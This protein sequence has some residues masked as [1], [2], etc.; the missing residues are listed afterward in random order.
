MRYAA[1]QPP[2]PPRLRLFCT[3]LL[4]LPVTQP[5]VDCMSEMLP[6]GV[7]PAKR[8]LAAPKKAATPTQS[9]P[10]TIPTT[11]SLLAAL[12]TQRTANATFPY[13]CKKVTYMAPAGG[14]VTLNETSA[15]GMFQAN[16]SVTGVSWESTG[17]LMSLCS[18][19][20]HFMCIA[21]QKL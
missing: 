6:C 19:T 14:A 16:R 2:V 12:C 21:L 1:C 10:A 13:G 7:R 3:K 17:A 8:T 9:D 15:L 5:F 20:W 4:A 11:A 18:M